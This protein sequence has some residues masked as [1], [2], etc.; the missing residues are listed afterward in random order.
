MPFL[1][2][3]THCFSSELVRVSLLSHDN[4]P[5]EVHG[6]E[7]TDDPAAESE[8]QHHSAVRTGR[9]DPVEL[10]LSVAPSSAR[11]LSVMR[12]ID[13]L[14]L[15]MPWYG[16]CQMT[17]ELRCAGHRV[18]RKRVCRLMRLTA[19]DRW[20]QGPSHPSTTQNTSVADRGAADPDRAAGIP[21]DCGPDLEEAAGGGG[22][23]ARPLPGCH[24]YP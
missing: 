16:S 5:W 6:S 1:G 14:Y 20:L 13:R 19:C 24:C 15:E 8:T 21:V 10:I 11:N 18:G 17:R 22:A 7:A 2:H 4:K 9:D 3:L 12:T 23:A